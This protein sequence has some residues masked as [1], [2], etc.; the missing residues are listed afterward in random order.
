MRQDQRSLRELVD[1]FSVDSG[2]FARAELGVVRAEIAEH[3]RTLSAG[4][5]LIAFAAVCGLTA[6]ATTA[7]AAILALTIVV[8][9]WVAALI[10]T[11]ILGLLAA[12]LLFGGLRLL[13][14]A[15]PAESVGSI[16]E[17]IACLKARARSGAT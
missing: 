9:A 13:R 6:F 15:A 11:A 5:A 17:D 4:A 7:A 14:R 1:Q 8:S 2:R 3:I 12:S 16:K 10:V